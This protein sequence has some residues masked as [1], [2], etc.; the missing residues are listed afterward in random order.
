MFCSQLFCACSILS[1]T[2]R[3]LLCVFPLVTPTARATPSRVRREVGVVGAAI[4]TTSTNELRTIGLTSARN[5]PGAIGYPKCISLESPMFKFQGTP[6]TTASSP[7][8]D[9]SRTTPVTWARSLTIE[10]RMIERSIVAPDATV[11]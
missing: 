4:Q 7:T 9:A 2:T 8:N 11:A 3:V 10:F 6:A 5:R 1:C